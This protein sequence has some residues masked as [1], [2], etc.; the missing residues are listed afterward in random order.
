[1]KSNVSTTEMQIFNYE[2]SKFIQALERSKV[3]YLLV[4][5]SDI[6]DP[7]NDQANLWIKPTEINKRKLIKAINN[8][9]YDGELLKSKPFPQFLLMNNI[10]LDMKEQMSLT[11]TFS[12][13]HKFS[14][15][16]KMASP[17][18]GRKGMLVPVVSQLK[19]DRGFY[20]HN[21]GEKS[22]DQQPSYSQR[23]SNTQGKGKTR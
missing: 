5:K 20:E 16:K 13:T 11:A 10:T 8:I 22:I 15:V 3:D 17:Q 4:T 18:H 19:L 6:I 1:M 12:K 23:V 2:H 9:G 7:Q 14:E 21:L